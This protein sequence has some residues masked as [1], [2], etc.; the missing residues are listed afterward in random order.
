VL[1]LIAIVFLLLSGTSACAQK[2]IDSTLDNLQQ[3]SLA[4]DYASL[5]QDSVLM[6]AVTNVA[7]RIN[8]ADAEVNK[9]DGLLILHTGKL[10]D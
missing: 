8:L 7:V 4:Q 5:A 9:A 3:P 2:N 6:P 1:K 10:Q